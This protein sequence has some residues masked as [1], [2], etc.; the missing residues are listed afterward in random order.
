[1]VVG[2]V[3][4]AA[5]QVCFFAGVART[6]VA[7]GTIVAIGSAPAIAGIAAWAVRRERPERGWT[8]ATLLAV[9]GCSLLLAPAGDAA[10]VDP[11]GVLLA[12][13]SGAGYA[14]YTLASKVL[15]DAGCRPSAAMAVAFSGAAVLLAPVVARAD[16]SWLATSRGVGMVLW[17]SVVTTAGAYVLYARGLGRLPAATVASLTLGEPLIAGLIGVLLLGERPGLLAALGAVLVAGGL[18]W[19][20]ARRPATPT[21][22]PG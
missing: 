12:L 9:A 2:A 1:A 19:L 22:P 18:V 16:L 13:A 14:S 6:G 10:T 8:T 4:I 5:Y 7:V 21:P 20:A 15:L 3:N 17:L 11:L